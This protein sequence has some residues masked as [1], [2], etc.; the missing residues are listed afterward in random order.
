MDI[1]KSRAASRCD[2]MSLTTSMHQP[3]RMQSQQL[4]EASTKKK[5]KRSPKNS[6][7]ASEAINSTTHTRIR[8]SS[9]CSE[10]GGKDYNSKMM[11][12]KIQ[13]STAS[14]QRSKFLASHMNPS[15]QN[16][17]FPQKTKKKNYH[18]SKQK[19]PV[20]LRPFKN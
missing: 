11:C 9:T 8:R 10:K 1:P 16:L 12:N 17:T 2:I 15:Y 19:K 7:R 3:D 18:H 14:I 4:K 6:H 20:N 13:P 5:K